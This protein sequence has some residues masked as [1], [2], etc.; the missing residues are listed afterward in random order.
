MNYAEVKSL[1]DAGFTVDEIR[2][3]GFPQNP[4]NN[5]QE[6]APV[7]QAPVEQAPVEQAPVE[8]APNEATPPDP[9]E[10]KFNQLTG[11]IEKLIKTI[12]VSNLNRTSMDTNNNPA[13]IDKQVDS[14][15]AGLIRPE[16]K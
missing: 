2:S 14:I 9:V 1:L 8:P 5:P 11:S 7:E 12:Q 10:E 16:K 13:D 4:Q 3:M 15:M 6:P